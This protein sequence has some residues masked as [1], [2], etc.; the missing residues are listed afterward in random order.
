MI[1]YYVHHQGR[2][3]LHRALCLSEHLREPVTILTSLPCSHDQLRGGSIVD[4]IPLA[5]D[6][7]PPPHEDPTANGVL[8]WAPPHHPGLRARSGAIAAWIERSAPTLMVID[9]SVEVAVLTRLMGIPVV[10]VAMHGKRDDRAHQIGYDLSTA[11]LACWPATSACTEWPTSWLDKTWF[12]GA[13][14]RYDSRIPPASAD[15]LHTRTRGPSGRRRVTLLLGAGGSDLQPRQI[16]DAVNATPDWDWDIIGGP[17]ATWRPD[18]WPSLCAADVIV[19]H[20]GQNAL[21]EV[22][23]SRTPALVVPQHRPHGEQHA[24]AVALDRAGIATVLPRWPHRDQWPG[25]LDKAAGSDG[26]RWA[27][28]CPGNGATHAAH[29]LDA[30]A[31]SEPAPL[32]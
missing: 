28:W 7:D 6:D 1:G 10:T 14:S 13:F 24:T 17:D 21:A 2:G 29:L 22:A 32:R 4:W 12:V 3:H 23:A 5:R 27:T 11:L 31:R 8:H 20:A 26:Q 9:V 30:L 16:R 18:P 19:T 15:P 25:L